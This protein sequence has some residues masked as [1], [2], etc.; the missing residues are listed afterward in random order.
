MGGKCPSG[1]I[2]PYTGAQEHFFRIS[3]ESKQKIVITTPMLCRP[4]SHILHDSERGACS[5]PLMLTHNED[6][7]R[8]ASIS[9]LIESFGR[10]TKDF[11][12]ISHLL[13]HIT[14]ESAQDLTIPY[15]KYKPSPHFK[16]DTILYRIYKSTLF[17]VRFVSCIE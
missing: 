8:I 14:S 5:H 4:Q 7:D 9:T 3:E 1:Y 13:N 15:V 10:I 17:C 12:Y 11:A 16:S 6:W 2:I